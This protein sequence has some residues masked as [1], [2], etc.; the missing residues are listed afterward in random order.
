[1]RQFYLTKLAFVAILAL[2]SMD[3]NSQTKA[4][5]EKIRSESNQKALSQLQVEFDENFRRNQVQVE[6][7]VV[8]MNVP[9]RFTSEDG[10]TYELQKIEAD[11]TPI[12]YQT[13]N[14]NAAKSTRTNFLQSGGGLGLE[15]MGL[16]M[17]AHVWDAG[18]ARVSH[19]EY[20]GPGGTDR[21]TLMDTA[22][23]GTQLH[24]HAAHVTGTIIASGFDPN[25]KGMAPYGKVNG[26]MW[27]NDL[28]EAANAA[29]N[30]MI[31]SNHSYGF[32]TI[33]PITGGYALPSYY[34]GAYIGESRDWDALMYNSPYYLMVTSAGNDGQYP[35]T[36]SPLEGNTGFDK[37]VGFSTSKNNLVVAN[38]NDAN[39]DGN[40][41]L[42]SVT[43]EPSS[44]QG[45]TDDYRIKPDITGNGVSL[46]STLHNANNAY[47]TFTGTSMSSPNV[48]GTLLL[49]QEHARNVT[50]NLY[51]AATIKGIVLHTAD[52][53]GMLGP[54]AVSG[55][56]LLNAK[57]AA[58]TISLNG[59]TSL[60]QE[61][62]LTNGQTITLTVNSDGVNPLKASISWTDPAGI[63]TTSLNN[64]TPRLVNDLD[65]RVTQGSDTFMPWRLIGV[66]VNEKGDNFRDPFERVDVD[67][68][69][70]TYTI[71]ISHKGTLT[72]GSQNFSLVITGISPEPVECGAVVPDGLSIG[73]LGHDKATLLWNAIPGASYEIAF[74]EVSSATWIEFTTSTNFYE[75]NGLSPE[76]SYEFKVKSICPNGSE[77]DFSPTETFTTSVFQYTYCDS[78]GLSIADEYIGR[79][80]LNTIDNPSDDQGYSNFTH[81]STNLNKNETYT[82]TITPVWTGSTYAEGYGVWIDFNNNG[83]FDNSELVFSLPPTT[84]ASISGSFTVPS[85]AVSGQTRMRVSMKYN[86]IP[87]PCEI[88]N[89]GE[90]EDYTVIITDSNPDIEPP[91]APTNLQASNV[92]TNSLTLS[93]NASSDNVGV[94]EYDVYQDGSYLASTSGTN[95]NVTGLTPETTYTYYVI[96]K[97]SA[98]NQSAPS[99]S[100][101]VTTEA[102]EEDPEDPE[103]PGE[104]CD[105]YGQ[106]IER[107]YINRVQFNTIHNTS[108]SNGGY[109]NY[110]NLSTTLNRG[111][112][113]T[114]TIMPGFS[115]NTR[116]SHGYAVWIDLNQNGIFEESEK[117]Y[118][119]APSVSA[120]AAGRIMIPNSA[121]SGP[122]RMRVAMKQE[123]NPSPCEVLAYGEV[124]DYTVIIAGGTNATNGIDNDLF[125]NYSIKIY[126]NPVHDELSLDTSAGILSIQILDVSGK[127]VM[128]AGSTLKLNVSHL[129]S[130]IYVL[131][132]ETEQGKIREKF[133]K[134]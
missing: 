96:A 13:D 80:Q 128:S 37:L 95:Y 103:E 81:I 19:Q 93:W 55:W 54:D 112:N 28:G 124:E 101:T 4:E 94:T 73:N 87:G 72:N 57:K 97:D 44:S 26:Y 39:I 107:G 131:V 50:G 79:V 21:V 100:L 41:N 18:H 127:A 98:G 64:T 113:Y 59:T 32:Q 104:Y 23:E 126:P 40:G 78:Y 108:G 42:I 91:T 110:T 109:G 34:A 102:E 115:S 10:V 22:S 118:S 67:A 130:G 24:Y 14:V 12:Y 6:N 62:S 7:Y 30:G 71:T 129:Q 99:N 119:K 85:T 47:G 8:R 89:Y 70:G 117:L 84:S 61:M 76:T 33:N 66:N 88:F 68:A 49:L 29:S 60:V 82:I 48:A 16:N 27:N 38:A 15:L 31:V 120:T 56:G 90:V 125:A 5:I 65:I 25:A 111:G 134:K 105:S 45:P 11:G 9:K 86:G 1:M 46:Y 123:G 116:Y 92:T 133:I 83:V 132:I 17:T 63:A 106:S 69:Y 3:L 75:V 77:S 51:R 43:M 121:M 114:I 20:D 58:E 53:I 74:K 36:N 35:I 2:L 52:D 122:T